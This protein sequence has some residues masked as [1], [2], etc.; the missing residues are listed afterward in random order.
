[1]QEGKLKYKRLQIGHIW[2]RT[3]IEIVL[4][5]AAIVVCSYLTVRSYENTFYEATKDS[6]RESTQQL[7]HS[8]SGAVD[9]EL[10]E[11][12]DPKR[13][14]YVKDYYSELFNACFTDGSILNSC[15]VYRVSGSDAVFFASCDGYDISDIDETKL[16]D[17]TSAVTTGQQ[18]SCSYDDAYYT[19]TPVFKDGQTSPCALLVVSSQYMNSFDYNSLVMERLKTIAIFSGLMIIVY[20]SISGAVSAYKKRKAVSVG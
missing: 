1:M 12:T 3:V 7:S 2:L 4:I 18:M 17:I 20:Y 19:Y 14:A 9:P 15:A 8:V 6:A 16:A 5:I 11:I 10:L 13:E